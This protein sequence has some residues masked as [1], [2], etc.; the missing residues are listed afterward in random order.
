[1]SYTGQ[2]VK[3]SARFV[4]IINPIVGFLYRFNIGPNHLSVTGTAFCAAAAAM[5][6][7]GEFFWAG[8]LYLIGSLFDVFDGAMARLI[9]KET[10]FGAFLD[11]VLDRVG[12]GLIFVALIHFYSTQSKPL[13]ATVA[14]ALLLN[15]FLSSFTRVKAESFLMECR[16]GLVTRPERVMLTC[17]GLLLDIMGFLIFILFVLSTLTVLQRVIHVGNLAK[18][19]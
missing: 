9:Q 15:S 7:Y 8:I 18:D 11:S 14:A 5:I 16:I 10:Q 3:F 17:A 2:R 6:V 19:E 13:I 1:M 12:E 4:G